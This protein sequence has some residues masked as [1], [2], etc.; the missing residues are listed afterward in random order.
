MICAFFS[1]SDNDDPVEQP[2]MSI[3]PDASLVLSAQTK[4]RVITK[5]V[6]DDWDKEASKGDDVIK[7]MAVVVFNAGAYTG[8]GYNAGD[9]VFMVS[10]S[11]TPDANGNVKISSGI[12]LLAGNVDMLLIGNPE[13]ELLSA[14]KGFIDLNAKTGHKN[15]SDV[16]ALTTSLAKEENVSENNAGKGITMS[17]QISVTLLAG[18][19]YIGLNKEKSVAVSTSDNLDAIPLV[20][21]VARVNLNQ[22]KLQLPSEYKAVRFYVDSVFIANAKNVSYIDNNGGTS[23]EVLSN[24]EAE[25]YS[26]GSNWGNATGTYKTQPAKYESFLGTKIVIGQGEAINPF[27]ESK[28]NAQLSYYEDLYKYGN[29]YFYVYPNQ[30]KDADHTLLIVKGDFWYSFDERAAGDDNSKLWEKM[31]N[32]YFTVVINDKEFIAQGD[33][34]DGTHVKR[35]TKYIVDL[36][37]AGSG[38]PDPFTPAA[39]A[40]V[41]AKVV[42]AKWSVI[43]IKEE[44]D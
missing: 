17:E 35:N 41:A 25:L 40:H 43:E 27:L 33:Y 4:D 34:A 7:T 1:C 19:N 10:G 23:C 5:S 44:V 12:G 26:I 38:S 20:R 11:V 13:P 6:F 2:K 32:R 28:G 37:I 3:V 16:L 42:V 30:A 15:K 39:F 9:V 31:N 22:L 21:T 29:K 24:S 8:H 18:D 36:T 14:I